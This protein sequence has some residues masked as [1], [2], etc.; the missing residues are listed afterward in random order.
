MTISAPVIWVL[1]LLLGRLRYELTVLEG[2]EQA[3]VQ[4]IIL[5]RREWSLLRLAPIHPVHRLRSDCLVNVI[6][7]GGDSFRRLI[8]VG[9][10]DTMVIEQLD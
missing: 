3:I 7:I 1:A 8:I 2:E 5:A 6:E 9:G 10:V 4:R